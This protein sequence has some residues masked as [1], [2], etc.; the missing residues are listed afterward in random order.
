M[1]LRKPAIPQQRRHLFFKRRDMGAS[2]AV[3]CCFDR[4]PSAAASIARR[5][6]LLRSLAVGCCFDRAPAAAAA[7]AQGVERLL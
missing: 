6:L 1:M 3:G 4:S 7:V 2:L 5:R